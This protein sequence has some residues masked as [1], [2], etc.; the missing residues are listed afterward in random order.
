M[1]DVNLLRALKAAFANIGVNVFMIAGNIDHFAQ[2]P[3][4]VCQAGHQIHDQTMNHHGRI[5]IPE[6]FRAAALRV[7]H[8][9]Q[10]HEHGL[11]AQDFFVVVIHGQNAP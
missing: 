5:H 10:K 3:V 11:A 7:H 8:V 2:I 6:F 4:F 1:R 9:A